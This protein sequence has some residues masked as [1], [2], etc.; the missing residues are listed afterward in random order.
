M[1]ASIDKLYF[2]SYNHEQAS[3]TVNIELI[4]S[5]TCLCA[6]NVEFW[7]LK[8]TSIFKNML[9]YSFEHWR[10]LRKFGKQY[11]CASK[12]SLYHIQATMKC[13]L[14]KQVSTNISS[15]HHAYFVVCWIFTTLNGRQRR[16]SHFYDCILLY[17]VLSLTHWSQVV[18]VT[19]GVRIM[20]KRVKYV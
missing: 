16:R 1:H 10:E 15:S 20:W 11:K 8:E 14:L 5:K 4:F 9:R 3:M 7:L 12:I 6:R 2:L 13:T 17:A 18:L 19:F